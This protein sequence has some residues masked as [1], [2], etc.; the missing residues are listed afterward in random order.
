[1]FILVFLKG[2]QNDSVS[3]LVC[4]I[5][6]CVLINVTIYLRAI[7]IIFG[8]MF[9]FYHITLQPVDQILFLLV[10][11]LQLLLMKLLIREMLIRETTTHPSSIARGSDYAQ[12]SSVTSEGSTVHHNF[13][14]SY[15]RTLQIM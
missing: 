3:E 9:Y 1:M 7:F 13:V 6:L 2:W 15:I 11:T 12:S 5:S 14:R 4:S 10:A 8:F